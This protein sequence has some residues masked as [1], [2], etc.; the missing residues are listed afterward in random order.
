MKKNIIATTWFTGKPDPQRFRHHS[1]SFASIEGWYN[2]IT[3]LRL[4]GLIFHDC[5]DA[6]FVETYSSPWV[7]FIQVDEFKDQNLCAADYRWGMYYDYFSKTHFDNIFTTDCND[8][9]IKQNP[10]L[11]PSYNASSIFIGA[12]NEPRLNKDSG[13]MKSICGYAYEKQQGGFLFYEKPILNCGIVGGSSPLFLKLVECMRNEINHISPCRYECA[14]R[15]I[16]FTVD[17]AVLNQCAYT[18]FEDA[19]IVSDAPVHS[20]YKKYQNHRE[21]I[22]FIHK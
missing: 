6:E 9:L 4:S 3:S 20:L 5:F 17:M 21:D 1:A 10:F 13:W 15:G 16:P 2:S 19:S 8:V 18:L 22:W 12:E 14:A 11:H 7:S